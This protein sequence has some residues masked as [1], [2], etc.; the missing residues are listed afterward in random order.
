ML[1]ASTCSGCAHIK[2]AEYG[3]IKTIFANGNNRLRQIELWEQ[4]QDRPHVIVPFD[5]GKKNW[6]AKKL[7]KKLPP[8]LMTEILDD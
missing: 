7:K 3:G 2:E 4:R 6:A 1:D 5:N 8:V